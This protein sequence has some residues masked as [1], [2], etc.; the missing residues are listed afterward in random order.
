MHRVETLGTARWVHALFSAALLAVHALAFAGACNAAPLAPRAGLLEFMAL[1]R[2]PVPG[3]HVNAAGGNYFHERVDL[4]LDTRLGPFAIGAVYNSASGWMWSFDATYRDGTLSDSTA[5][6]MPMSSLAANAAEPGT[7]WVKLDATRV[8]TKGGLVHEFDASSGRLLAIYWSSSAYPRLR[9]VQT[10]LGAQWRTSAIE[11]CTSATA[12]SP[13]F[14][15][16]YDPNA[17]LTRIDDRA[18]RTALFA[19]DAAGQLA[20]ARDG[21][22]VAKGWPGE[23]Y[24]YAGNLLASISSSEGERIEIASDLLGRTTQVR[25]V[26]EGDPTWRF[27]YELPNAAGISVTAATDPLGFLTSYAIDLS[28]RVVSVTNP[29]AERTDFTWSGLRPA[30][31][32]L[33]DGTLDVWTWADDEV[34]SETSSSGNVR[35]FTYR[36]DGVNR[37]QPSVRPLLDST[38]ALGLLERRLYDANGRLTSITNGA[39]ETTTYAYG[40]DQAVSSITAP[41]G[42]EL[43]LASTGDHGWPSFTTFASSSEAAVDSYDAVGNR[44]YGTTPDSGSGGVVQRSFDADRNLAAI[45][46]IDAPAS[47]AQT[48]QTITLEHRS[49]GQLR[50]VLRPSGGATTFSYDAFGRLAAIAEQ[51][52]PGATPQPGAESRT[53]IARDLLGRVIAVERANGMREER[54]YDPAGR[55]SR[56]RTL[57]NG[58]LESDVE[59]LFAAGRLVR[60]RDARGFDEAYEYDAAGRLRAVRHSQGETTR[61]TY[62]RRS[63]LTQTELALPG[64]S[65]LALLVHGY[66]R[67]DREISLGYLGAN[68]IARQFVAG[69]VEHTYY[70]N[71]VR[72]DHFRSAQSG[73]ASGRELWRNSKRIE[74]SDYVLEATPGGAITQLR[75]RVSDGTSADATTQEDFDY[76]A[77]G[78]QNSM[79][80]RVASGL[81]SSSGGPA[82]SIH[83]DALSNFTGGVAAGMARAVAYN[84]ERNRVLSAEMPSS[85]PYL[86]AL[87]STFAHDAGGFVVSETVGGFRFGSNTFSWNAGGQLAAIHSDGAL[88]ASFSYDALGRRSER[89]LGGTT[90]RWR[91]GGLVETSSA[92]QPLAIDFGE[93]RIDLTGQHRFRHADPRGNPKHVT[94]AAGRLVRHNVYSAYGQSGALGPQADDV[95]FAGGTPIATSHGQYLLIGA[96]LYAP[97]LARFLAPDPVWNPLNA[98]AYTLGNPVDFWDP[99]G[100]HAGSH[101]DLWQGRIGVA[102]SVLAFTGAVLLFV[103]APVGVPAAVAA[104]AV[105]GL[106]LAVVDSILE[107][108]KVTHAHNEQSSDE[109]GGTP[110]SRGG[111]AVSLGGGGRA[112]NT[113]GSGGNGVVCSDDGMR[114]ICTGGSS[115]SGWTTNPHIALD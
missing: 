56:R 36:T 24:A 79:E 70:G 77:R 64:A 76:A 95:G 101:I 58:V 53:T 52:S 7:H 108:E 37:E 32:T 110:E 29:L 22:D 63:R 65:P 85:S 15:L 111:G 47:G 10:Q 107:L 103:A 105:A 86:P 113:G 9:F 23:R 66:D 3:G 11:Q 38:D 51:A 40:A 30:S 41:D 1:S 17:R 104:V 73:R 115:A 114:T 80:R 72:Q 19:Y 84:A 44:V 43:R 69:R 16:A 8:K 109:R 74:K 20:S 99:A 55:I 5:A 68:L 75:S 48:L 27:D 67:A 62:D 6:S 28:A 2:I 92:G 102:R 26:G 21:L 94:N 90:K 106:G 100:L 12:C 46:V 54:S 97:M 60:A 18:G 78:V 87:T 33:P 45:D 82:E 57:R 25:A 4:E 81:A 34:A 61:L 88:V 14:R 112:G 59:F 49:D 93:V 83:Y 91:F 42:T 13:V 96:R 39:S 31:R 50:R 89:I 35:A 98:Y 71:G